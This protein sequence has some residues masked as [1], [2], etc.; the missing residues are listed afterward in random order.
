MLLEQ[1]IKLTF[2]WVYKT[3][4]AS[5]FVIRELQI[6]SEHTIAVW[7][8]Y[9]R[10]NVSLLSK[11]KENGQIGGVSKEIETGESKF[12]KRKKRDDGVWYFGRIERGSKKCFL[13]IVED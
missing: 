5:E 11:R 2:Y 12:G 9:T 3:P 13:E 4:L 10:K 1:A 7:Y 6:C 8:N